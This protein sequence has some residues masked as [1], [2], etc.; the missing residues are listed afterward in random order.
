M[1]EDAPWS[2]LLGGGASLTRETKPRRADAIR[3]EE[4]IINAALDHFSTH[5]VNAPLDGIAKQAG[6]G[7]GTLYRHFP[8]R[9]RIIA[10]AL[11]TCKLHFQDKK[12]SLLESGNSLS[13]LQE[14]LSALRN[15]V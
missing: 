13:G 3:N 6:V 8:T 14:W 4:R 1:S 15:Y 7:P 10:A 11:S 12:V 9:D 5:G 2:R